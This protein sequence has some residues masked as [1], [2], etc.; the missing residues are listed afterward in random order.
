MSEAESM[1]APVAGD[2]NDL[3]PQIEQHL[4]LIDAMAALNPAFVAKMRLAKEGARNSRDAAN[5]QHEAI[6]EAL[7]DAFT[8]VVE[9]AAVTNWFVFVAMGQ[10]YSQ[11]I[12]L[13]KRFADSGGDPFSVPRLPPPAPQ[14]PA[15]GMPGLRIGLARQSP[16]RRAG[17]Q[18]GARELCPNQPHA[19]RRHRGDVR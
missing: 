17:V 8:G 6:S 12:R 11:A 1:G 3:M 7:K 14:L 18:G 10:G 4:K 15:A 19:E 13:L 5:A 16:R 2:F 9:R